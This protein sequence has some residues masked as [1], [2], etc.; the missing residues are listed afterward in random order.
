MLAQ[1]D[2][3]ASNSTATRFLSFLSGSLIKLSSRRQEQSNGRPSEQLIVVSLVMLH[4]GATK[5]H[6]QVTTRVVVG[7]C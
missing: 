7:Y 2:E 4:G 3:F 6:S 5:E 1:N